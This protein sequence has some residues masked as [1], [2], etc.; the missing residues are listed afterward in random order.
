[1]ALDRLKSVAH[2]VA[3]TTSPP[4][5]FDPLSSAEIETAAHIIRKAYGKVHYNAITLLEPRKREM[6][7]WLE[8]PART[9]RPVRIADVVAIAPG[10]KVYDGL[11]NLEEG[12][13]TKW[14]ALEG[15]QPL[16]SF[17][18]AQNNSNLTEPDHNGR[19][20]GG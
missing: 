11:V 10:G 1:M 15:V 14:T 12:N 17:Q 6:L 20:T 19:P 5:P 13:I 7:K 3:G 18:E 8:D 2:H 9:P 16:V 4:H